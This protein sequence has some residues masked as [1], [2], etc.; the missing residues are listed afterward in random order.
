MNE[1]FELLIIVL[2]AVAGFTVIYK[3]L[4][5]RQF[6]QRKPKFTL[7]PKYRANFEK[8]A[9][10]IESALLAQEFKKKQN[11]SY[12]RG[13]VYGDFSAKSIKLLVVINESSSEIFVCSSFFGILFDTGDIWQVTSDILNG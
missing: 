1:I 9:G 2:V 5:F 11:G 4:P 10:E 12:T 13:K 3:V 6:V 8:P 7:F